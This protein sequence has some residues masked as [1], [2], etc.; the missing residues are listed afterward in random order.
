MKQNDYEGMMKKAGLLVSALFFAWIVS[1][2]SAF[3]YLLQARALN[4]RGKTTEAIA[5]LSGVISNINDHRLF[6]ERADL[7]ILEGDYKGAIEDYNSSNNIKPSSGEYGLSR[8]YAIQNNVAVSISHLEK[9]MN[10]PFKRSEKEIMLDPAFSL[11]ENKPE[12]RQ[13][14]KNEWYNSIEKGISE[15]EFYLSAGKQEEAR[16]IQSELE[17]EYTDYN[18][19]IYGDALIE[20]SS[21]KFQEAIK[22]LNRLIS[23]KP[24]NEK[25]LRL[26]A[27]SQSAVSNYAG[28]SLTYCKLIS[29]ETPDA[30]L[31]IQ[32]AE[33]YRKTGEW[34]RS[35]NDIEKYLLIYPEDIKG[36][37]MAGKVKAASGD[38]LKALEFFSENIRL[39]PNDPECYNDRAD[40]YLLSRSWN[41][42]IKDYSMSLDLNPDNSDSWLNKGIALINIGNTD[43]AC[44]DFKNSLNKGNKRAT[45]YISKYCIK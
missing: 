41:L 13:F 2:Q 37:S 19:I 32:R 29:M 30:E 27:R 33:C 1:G 7:R 8:I 34:E 38:N 5:M 17:K 20:Y 23:V 18:E 21:G 14:W 35:M 39:H 28:A 45:E 10:S 16:A 44:H 31:Y 6:L 3:D 12:W 25:Y 9:S 4:Q 43:D 40:A 15:I 36:L 42:A 22:N 11:L 26:F 24:D